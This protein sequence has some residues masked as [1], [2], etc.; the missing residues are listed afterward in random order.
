M[1]KDT[2]YVSCKL[3]CIHKCSKIPQNNSYLYPVVVDQYCPHLN[4][5]KWYYFRI[6]VEHRRVL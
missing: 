2:A 1:S 6:N 4:A 3:S 5:T